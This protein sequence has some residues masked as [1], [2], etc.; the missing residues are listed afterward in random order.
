M[1]GIFLVL[2]LSFSI[3]LLQ[4]QTLKPFEKVGYDSRNDEFSILGPYQ[5][6]TAL[7]LNH[8]GKAEVI[9]FDSSG[10]KEA[11]ILLEAYDKKCSHLHFQCSQNF[12]NVYFERKEKQTYTL[13]V[14]SLL[15]NQTF[16]EPKAIGSYEDHFLRERNEYQ[17][18]ISHDHSKVLFYTY[19]PGEEDFAL[20]ALVLN[21]Q[22]ELLREVKQLL[23]KNDTRFLFQQAI[24]NDGYAYILISADLD[25]K[26]GADE[27]E[28]L[29]CKRNQNM[30]NVRRLPLGGHY[31]NDISL[32]LDDDS[33]LT[34]LTGFYSDSKLGSVKGIYHCAAGPNLFDDLLGYYIP[35]SLRGS[36]AKLDFHDVNTQ[37]ISLLKDGGIEIIT[38]RNYKVQTGASQNL[39][40]TTGV[41]GMPSQSLNNINPTTQYH[42]EEI[43]IFNL[44]RENT[45]RWSQTVLKDQV[46]TDD[47]GASSSFACMESRLGKVYIFNELNG[48]NNRLM[49]CYV[50]SKGTI[51]LKEINNTL[52]DE[53]RYSLYPRYSFQ[54]NTNEILMPSVY[55]GYLCLLRLHF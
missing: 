11:T 45:L 9:L 54:M 4:G 40:M 33:A 15:E 19:T 50:S 29:T 42:N 34:H 38:E 49:A 46:T 6:K 35:L 53:D 17:F 14:S 22:G 5:S 32:C 27:V 25:K 47:D 44:K 24:S 3:G 20:Q 23:P 37:L 48:R 55:K 30:F 39:M 16:S 10:K 43:S 52:K 13:Y 8:N 31:L 1:K 7:Y 21:E 2:L 51:T 12:L 26:G 36:K 41:M 18:A 28:L